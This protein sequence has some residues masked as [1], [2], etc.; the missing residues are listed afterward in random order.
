MD[1]N[2]SVLGQDPWDGR[3]VAMAEDELEEEAEEVVHALPD[4]VLSDAS[5]AEAG[6]LP[7]ADAEIE[8]SHQ[9]RPAPIGRLKSSLALDEW[10]DAQ[11][12]GPNDFDFEEDPLSIPPSQPRPEEVVEKKEPLPS[13]T[14]IDDMH[15][16]LEELKQK[17]ADLTLGQN[18]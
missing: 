17:Q 13:S 3:D 1:S 8:V 5:D 10:T 12:D 18:F 16:K 9:E 7:A 6:D 11:P 2:G 14:T 15:R 4:G